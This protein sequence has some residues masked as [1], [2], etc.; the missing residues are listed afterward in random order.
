MDEITTMKLFLE[1]ITLTPDEFLQLIEPLNKFCSYLIQAS[2]WLFGGAQVSQFLMPNTFATWIYSFGLVV[3]GAFLYVREETLKPRKLFKQGL[4]LKT[5]ELEFTSR[6]GISSEQHQQSKSFLR[7]YEPERELEGVVWAYKVLAVFFASIA[8]GG[9]F[10]Q[11]TNLL[12]IGTSLVFMLM[13][14]SRELDA[15]ILLEREQKGRIPEERMVAAIQEAFKDVQTYHRV[16]IGE[17]HDLDIFVRFPDKTMFAISVKNWGK[18]KIVFHEQR[19]LLCLRQANRSLR[20]LDAP[21]PLTELIEHELWLRKNN[22]TVFGGSSRDS[23]RPVKKV[24]AFAPPTIIQGHRE[25]L[26]A[27][28]GDQ[29]FVCV[30]RGKSSIFIISEDKLIDFIRVNI[31]SYSGVSESDPDNT[32][33]N[34]VLTE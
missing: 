16:Q 15:N 20:Y 4:S 13:V 10:Y 25:N 3:V 11:F 18:G 32:S 27:T 7:L 19:N 9:L 2:D 31:G 21:E 23:R 14:I 12:V 30:E 8:V 34:A 29:K 17:R 1:Y 33:T 28:I 24:L 5:T 6:H 26:Y 22:R